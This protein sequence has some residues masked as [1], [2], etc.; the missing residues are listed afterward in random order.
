VIAAALVAGPVAGAVLGVLARVSGG[1]LG[2]GRLAQIGPSAWLVALVGAAVV[3]VSALI[4]AS[5]ARAFR[6]GARR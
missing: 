1:P 6:P 4:G 2:D 5:A 3:A